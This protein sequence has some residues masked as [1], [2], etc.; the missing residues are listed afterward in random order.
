MHLLTHS[1]T[2][3][4]WRWLYIDSLLQWENVAYK[5]HAYT[6][7]WCTFRWMLQPVQAWTQQDATLWWRHWRFAVDS[8]YA[9]H[10]F[11]STILSLCSVTLSIA[12][13]FTSSLWCWCSSTAAS[14]LS[15]TPPSIASSKRASNACCANRYPAGSQAWLSKETETLHDPRRKCYIR[16]R[17]MCESALF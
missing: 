6:V 4:S 16:S 2:Q 11:R 1:C 7:C 8:S 15:S 9:G 14:T 5:K 3:A 17:V 13:T 12:P 10:P